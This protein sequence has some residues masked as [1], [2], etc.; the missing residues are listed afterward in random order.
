MKIKIGDLIKERL[1]LF[2]MSPSQLSRDTG[3]PQ[4]TISRIISGEIKSPRAEHLPAIA[5][6]LNVSIDWLVTGRDKKTNIKDTNF[7]NRNIIEIPTFDI[8]ASMGNGKFPPDFQQPVLTVTV[9]KDFFVNQGINITSNSRLSIITG[10]GDS[11]EGTFNNG[12]PVVVNHGI[13]K[14]DADGVYVFTLGDKLYLKRL[15][16]LPSCVRMISDNSK[17]P[18]YDIK[19]DELNNLIIHGKVLFAWNGRRI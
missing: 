2:N 13:Q 18:P 7:N 12:D 1:N 5:K 11:M 15:Q 14:L 8:E 10:M 4:G 16:I 6:A 3:I 19:G 17:Y 9:D